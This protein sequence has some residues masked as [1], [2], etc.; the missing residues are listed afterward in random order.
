MN[1]KV[2]K[3]GFGGIVSAIPKSTKRAAFGEPLDIQAH[4]TSM[5][6]ATFKLLSIDQIDPSP[7]QPRIVFTDDELRALADSISESSQA[8]PIIVRPMPSGRYELIG[9][10][11]RW[12]ACKLLDSQTI[13]CLVKKL[14]D[15]QAA[16]FAVI[17]NDSRAALSEYEK[18]RSYKKFL[19]NGIA[20]NQAVLAK[21]IGVS[22]ASVTRCMAFFK[23]PKEILA[24][25]DQA[26]KMLGGR[27]VPDFAALCNEGHTDI[28][29]KHMVSIFND[30]IA[31]D[32]ALRNARAEIKSAANP[33][34]AAKPTEVKLENG[35]VPV[36]TVRIQGKRDL[37]L[38]CEKDID[39]EKVIRAIQEAIATSPDQ[40]RVSAP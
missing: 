28:A 34:I 25:L 29:V 20:E 22:T 32:V 35:G 33:K 21:K 40:F 39:P 36:A 13:E 8:T 17:D 15:E 6:N 19:E 10:E 16:L 3:M 18:A 37:F 31:Q 24:L 4:V 30:G 9:G 2:G 1:A 27:V 26:P 23:L 5:D 14:T 11:R 38:K 7:Y 12:R